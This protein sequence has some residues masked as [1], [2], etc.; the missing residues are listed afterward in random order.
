MLNLLAYIKIEK[1][2]HLILD[3]AAFKT[4]QAT[5]LLYDITSVN[6][7]TALNYSFKYRL[8]D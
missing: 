1:R 5:M 2:Y 4:N 7:V 3:F 6:Y 8:N